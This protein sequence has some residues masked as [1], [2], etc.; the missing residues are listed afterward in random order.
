M[1]VLHPPITLRYDPRLVRGAVVSFWRRN[2]GTRF[3]VALLVLVAMTAFLWMRGERGFYVGA[4]GSAVFLTLMVV[5]ALFLNH[6][7]GLMSRLRRF[8]EATLELS[9]EGFTMSTD[10]GH[11]RLPW[12]AVVELW[13]FP[14]VWLLCVYSRTQFIT[15]PLADV[16]PDARNIIEERVRAAGGKVK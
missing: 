8:P 14:K 16:P 3:V 1:I 9:D 12:S 7:Q 13:R 2:L 15:L 10:A 6:Y 5:L 4:L 11:S